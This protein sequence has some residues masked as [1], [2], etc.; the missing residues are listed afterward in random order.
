MENLSI[1][2]RKQELL[3]ARFSKRG[4]SGSESNMSASSTYGT[5]N[6]DKDNDSIASFQDIS[7]KGHNKKT[8]KRKAAEDHANKKSNATSKKINQY[9]DVIPKRSGN[10]QNMYPLMTRNLLRRETTNENGNDN[11]AAFSHSSSGS[12]PSA[13]HRVSISRVQTHHQETQTHLCYRDI[14]DLEKAAAAPTQRGGTSPESRT[15]DM[16]SLEDSNNRLTIQLNSSKR[17]YSDL[18]RQAKQ[19]ALFIKELLIKSTKL[20][21]EESRRKAMEGKRRLGQFVR[22]G[23]GYQES[24]DNGWAFANLNAKKVKMQKEKTD[25][26]NMRKVLS[27]QRRPGQKSKIAPT[28]DDS[29]RGNQKLET[30]PGGEPIPINEFH[31]RDEVLKIRMLACKRDEN[32]LQFELDRLERE[33]SLH[34]RELKRINNEDNSDFNDNRVLHDRYLLLTLL[35]KGGFSEVYKGFDLEE[36]RYV[37]VKIHHLNREWNEQKKVDYA[38]HANRESEIH[39]LVDHPRIVGLY[40]RFEVDI[41]TFCTVLEFCEGNDLDF[42]LKQHKYMNEKEARTIIMQVV[43]ALNY[44]NNLDRPVIHY[45]LKPGNILLCNG[46][47]CGDIKITDFGLSKRLNSGQGPNEG[48]ELTSQGAGTYWYLPPE[49][50]FLMPGGQPPKIDNKVDVWSVG[51]IFYQCLFG[52][53]P[54]GHNLTQEAILKQDT[55]L[56]ATDVSFPSKPQVSETAKS[57]IKACLAYEKDKRADV[58]QLYAHPY[59]QPN[60]RRAPAST[61]ASQNNGLSSTYANAAST[62]HF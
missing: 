42:Y 45:D 59:L 15:P 14:S 49:C 7:E 23:A 29:S 22:R 37:A 18:K 11:N 26:E 16:I 13:E 10:S 57:F 3:E 33:R 24:W 51:V 5:G 50:F 61:A 38:R 39:R 17:L 55:I 54:F 43:N 27:R 31:E 19:S 36:L 12:L 34:I 41:N 62:T 1:D 60:T 20:E 28:N 30:R 8:R 47:V 4:Q 25:I 44:L 48:M 58:F 56:R 9:M 21:K 46:T 40:D 53:K 35:G 32:E 52:K 6:S 2:Q